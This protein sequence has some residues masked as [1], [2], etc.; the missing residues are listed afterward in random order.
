MNEEDEALY[1]LCLGKVEAE[2][3][4]PIISDLIAVTSSVGFFHSFDLFP[5]F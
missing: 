1:S 4:L 2:I 5:S 3:R